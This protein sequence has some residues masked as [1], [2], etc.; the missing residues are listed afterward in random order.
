[1]WIFLRVLLVFKLSP[2]LLAW[3][4]IYNIS[5]LEPVI[6]RMVEHRHLDGVLTGESICHRR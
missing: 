6:D 5:A 3:N 2:Y 1:M 4:Q